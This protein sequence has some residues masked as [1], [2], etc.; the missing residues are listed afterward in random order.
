MTGNEWQRNTGKDQELTLGWN[1]TCVSTIMVQCFSLLRQDTPKKMLCN[2]WQIQCVTEECSRNIGKLNFTK[3]D[4]HV[5][6]YFEYWRSRS[7]DTHFWEAKFVETLNGCIANDFEW[8]IK[9]SGYISCTL[10]ILS[11][12]NFLIM[13]HEKICLQIYGN[14]QKCEVRG[15]LTSV[16]NCIISRTQK[17]AIQMKRSEAQ[18]QSHTNI[19]TASGKGAQTDR[20]A[21]K[22]ITIT[23]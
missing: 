16:T 14:L 18:S 8:T 10:F 21:D 17:W 22:N 1:R 12:W 6:M 23:T 11:K 3:R 4:I 13:S 20:H 2:R 19:Q 5:N 9:W 15:V 7:V